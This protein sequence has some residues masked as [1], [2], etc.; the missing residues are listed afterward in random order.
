MKILVTVKRVTDYEAKI[1]IKPDGSGVVTDG[2]NMIVNPFDEIAVEEALRLKEKGGGAEV[3]VLSI[4]PKDAAQQIRSALAMG[5]DRGIL[6]E[7]G[8]LDSDAVSAILAGVV[9]KEK[10]DLVIIG[11][12]AIDDDSGQAGQL[13]AE[14]LGWGQACFASKLELG[15]GKA[16]VTREV[17]GGHDV[18]E[19]DLPAVVTADLRLNEPRYASL[20][21]IMKAKK[22]PLE[23]TTPNALGVDVKPKV[24]VKRFE[25]PAQRKAGVRVPDVP[26]LVAKLKD[27]AKAL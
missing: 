9:N 26:T 14:R 18:V 1:K 8:E 20:P 16:T 10:P 2:I 11:K 22:K 13:L 6:V 12:Q 23:E 17:D 7:S 27:E 19:I 15:S 5:A 25:E 4:G 24:L 21:G 3:V